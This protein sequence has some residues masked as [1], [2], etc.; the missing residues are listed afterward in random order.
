MGD[1][2]QII[3]DRDATEKE[4]PLLAS[5]ICDW[6]ISEGIIEA[7]LTDCVLG[8]KLG[9]APGPNHRKVADPGIGD[10]Y[11]DGMKIIIG[12]TV[13]HSMGAPVEMVCTICEYR[14]EFSE[15]A[16]EAVSE[17]Y[18][19]RGSGNF[20]CPECGVEWPLAEWQFEP[21]WGFGNLGFEFWNWPPFEAFF[22]E[23]I[24]RRLEHRVVCVEGKL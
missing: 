23:E 13:F 12:R 16:A 2:F 1:W 3:V 22:I 11:V 14:F 17:W 18:E 19:R 5:S 7:K 9:H 24:S 10:D 6:L 20:S 4:A 15:E 21:P 8:D